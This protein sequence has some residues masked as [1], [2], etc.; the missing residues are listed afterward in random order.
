MLAFP[1][2]LT[3][4]RIAA[5]YFCLLSLKLIPL[6]FFGI[7]S[8]LTIVRPGSSVEI[9]GTPEPL[10]FPLM[11][12]IVVGLLLVPA[13]ISQFFEKSRHAFFLS[14]MIWIVSALYNLPFALLL[15]LTPFVKVN[16]PWHTS[17]SVILVMV[18]LIGVPSL[19]GVILSLLS[20]DLRRPDKSPQ[21]SS[22]AR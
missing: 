12:A 6:A 7:A 21:T 2:L 18:I 11:T 19:I 1:S 10:F 4:R 15:V 9:G 22:N 14:N 8:L 13:Y 20:I 5:G 16:G 3:R 17:L